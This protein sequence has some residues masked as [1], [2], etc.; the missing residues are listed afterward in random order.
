MRRQADNC[1][2]D[3]KC[4]TVLLFLGM[5]VHHGYTAEVYFSF[6]L[7]GHTHEDIDLLK[8]LNSMYETV[9]VCLNAHKVRAREPAAQET[10]CASGKA[11]ARARQPTAWRSKPSG[12]LSAES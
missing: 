7:V 6:L 2:S 12:I 1:A 11:A 8:L 4:W 5:L 10:N 3:N 9:L